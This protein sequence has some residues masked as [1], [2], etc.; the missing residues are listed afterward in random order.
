ML[1]YLTLVNVILTTH[2]SIFL[3]Y[4]TEAANLDLF[5]ISS[6]FETN[7]DL[8]ETDGHSAKFIAMGIETKNFLINTGSIFFWVFIILKSSI[9]FYM[10]NSLC[11]KFP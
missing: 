8:K 3:G 11:A 6:V 7:L 9:F 4:L 1:V 2:P 5:D 10:I